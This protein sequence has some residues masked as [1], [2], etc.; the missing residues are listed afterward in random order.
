MKEATRNFLFGLFVLAAL[1]VFGVLMVW[2]GEAPE[3]LGTGDWTLEITGVREIRGIGEGSPVLLNG[4]EIGRVVG[5][6][7]VDRTIPGRPR[8]KLQLSLTAHGT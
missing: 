6:D 1:A 4:V 2:F 5:L 3:W 7:F 8:N